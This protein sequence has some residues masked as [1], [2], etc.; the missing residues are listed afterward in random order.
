VEHPQPAV[1]LVSGLASFGDASFGGAAS[2]GAGFPA[3]SS[4]AGFPASSMGPVPVSA[5]TPPLSVPPP[6][7]LPTSEGK[8]ADKIEPLLCERGSM[9]LMELASALG[10]PGFYARGKVV[11]ALNDMVMQGRVEVVPAPAG[12]PQLKK[13]DF[14]QYR[15][16]A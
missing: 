1:A 16:R 8:F 2:S 3:S 6:V 15:M 13:V 14:I 4:G 10:M 5:V 7:S 11:L 12:T 9:T